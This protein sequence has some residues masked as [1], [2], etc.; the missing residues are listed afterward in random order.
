MR[1]LIEI[2]S[3]WHRLIRVIRGS[4]PTIPD[5][6]FSLLFLCLLVFFVAIQNQGRVCNVHEKHEK[7]QKEKKCA[8]QS[9][10]TNGCRGQPRHLKPLVNGRIPAPH[11]HTLH[12]LGVKRLLVLGI[13]RFR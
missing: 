5:G 6:A 9:L 13:R 7:A 2:P 1:C 4:L 3:D 10:R 8:R 11:L 12:L